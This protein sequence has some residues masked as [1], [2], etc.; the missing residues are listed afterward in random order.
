MKNG[1]GNQLGQHI[2]QFISRFRNKVYLED[3]DT[4]TTTDVLVREADGEVTTVSGSVIGGVN[5]VDETTSGTS[6]GTP[7][8]VNPT[9]GTVLVQSMAFNGASNIG[10]VPAGG[11]SSTYLEGDGGWGVPIG[12]TYSAMTTSTLGLGRL[13]YAT[14]AT[15]TAN[16]QTTTAERTYGVTENSSNQLVVNVPW[17]RGSGDVDSVSAQVPSTST[18]DI[19][20]ISPTTGAVVVEPHVY[21]GTTNIG[22]VPTGGSYVVVTLRP[23]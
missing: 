8:V 6:T 21:G 10:H 18:G 4:G 20:S 15:P 3:V 17:L 9:T 23:S 16:A 22:A 7:I 5:S 1:L 12:T 13:R 2:W 19:L 14:G 11:T